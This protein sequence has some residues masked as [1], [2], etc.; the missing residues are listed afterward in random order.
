MAEQ[1]R[2][3]NAMLN[4]LRIKL[5]AWGTYWGNDG[6]TLRRKKNLKNPT[7]PHSQTQKTQKLATQTAC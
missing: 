7:F 1:Y 3:K 2:M 5:R 6:S 4:V